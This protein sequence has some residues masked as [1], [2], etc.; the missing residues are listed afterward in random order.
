MRWQVRGEK[1]IARTA[2]EPARYGATGTYC[3]DFLVRYAYRR[4]LCRSAS[5][6]D[7]ADPLAFLRR[8]LETLKL[9]RAYQE[10]MASLRPEKP[11]GD[12]ALARMQKELEELRA[13]QESKNQLWCTICHLAGHTPQS[14]PQKSYCHFCEK[15]GHED[16]DCYYL[17]GLRQ[18][19]HQLIQQSGGS[20]N[21]VVPMA[22]SYAYPQA[23][24]SQPTSHLV[25]S[26]VNQPYF[27]PT[28]PLP[29]L[30][31][32]P[33]QPANPMAF[34]AGPTPMVA[35]PPRYSRPSLEPS[36]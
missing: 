3:T 2:F 31:S 26:Y 4:Q 35:P 16:K 29:P 5:P 19:Q 27:Q 22:T 21:T 15:S 32:N 7:P 6:T 24:P 14:C 20:G 18:I 23:T 11:S 33:P 28:A 8:E 34:V 9:Q 13:Q 17:K 30:L 1:K 25:A 10:E 12:G 36:S